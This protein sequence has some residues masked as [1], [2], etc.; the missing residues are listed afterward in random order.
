MDNLNNILGQGLPAELVAKLQEAFDVKVNE[1]R[2]AAEMQVR[3]E[4]AQRYEHDKN[5]LVEAMDR[6]LT[7]VVTTYE[8]QKAGE[9]AT[10]REAQEKFHNGL[11]EAK[12]SYAARISEHVGKTND[13]VSKHLAEEVKSLRS[14]RAAL[15]EAKVKANESI[16]TVKAKLTEAHNAHV[17]KID[18]FVIAQVGRELTEFDQDRRALVETRAKL[19]SESRRKLQETQKRFVKEAASKLDTVISGQL[20]NEVKQL[21]EDIE[22][23]RQNHFGRKIFEAV[24]AEF[25][26]SQFVEG[27]EV[28]KLQQMLESSKAELSAAKQQ[29]QESA[30]RSDAAAR[31]AKL[32]EDRSERARVMSELLSNLRGEKRAVMEGMLD[33]VK[34]A[35]LRKSFSR[36]LPL[37]TETAT[38]KKPMAAAPQTQTRAPLAETRAPRVVTGDQRS[39]RLSESLA[40]EKPEIDEQLS[41]VVRLAGIHKN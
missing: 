36:F 12:A 31:K 33:S 22:R 26:G 32:A 11:S 8:T 35:E 41:T 40:A 7:D 24:V 37:V 15:S 9:I 5:E 39:N 20:A 23:N 27:T 3:E 21:H 38:A 10:L 18:E 14:E 1:A 17:K 19:V 4:L 28:Q 29:L 6:A 13:F 2:E 30:E 34:T 16:Q 25:M